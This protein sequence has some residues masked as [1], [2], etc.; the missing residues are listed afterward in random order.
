MS[1]DSMAQD[2]PFADLFPR[3]DEAQWQALVARVLKGKPFDRLVGRTADGLAIQPLYARLLEERPRAL[4]ETPGAWRIAARIDQPDPEEARA[5]IADDLAN[6]A[7][8]LHLVFGG[9]VGAC[10]FGLAHDPASLAT[11]LANVDLDAGLAIELD[12]GDTSHAA[13]DAFADLI[14]SRHVDPLRN[15]LAFGLDPFGPMLISGSSVTSMAQRLDSMAARCKMFAAR[16]FA[17]RF[18]MADGRPV[19]AAGGSEA[20]E[21]AFVLAAGIA[22][23]RALETAGIDLD[24]ARH[25]VSFRLVA[26]ADLF[27]TVAKLRALRALWSGVEAACGLTPQPLHLHVE[28]AWRMMSRRD[29]WVNL[30]R[31]TVACLGA[32]V[33][34]AD[35]VSVQPFTQALG[36]PDAFAR[37]LARNTQSILIA[38]AGIG[39]VADPVAGA[40]GFEALTQDMGIQAWALFQDIER[41]GGLRAQLENGRF[42]TQVGEAATQRAAR[43]ARRELPLTGTSEYP[44][45]AEDA[46]H[47]VQ[48]LGATPGL[49]SPHD[50]IRC[51]P[52][53]PR[54]DAAPYEALRDA[55][56]RQL[57]TTGQRPRVFLAN[58]GTASD[59]TPRTLF[60]RSL[61]E[62]GGIEAVGHDGYMNDGELVQAFHASG[63]SIACLCS[64]DDVY[65]ERAIAAAMALRDAGARR[66]WLAGR[67]GTL[68]AEWN[69]A[70][71][72]DFIFAGC[73][74]IAV[75]T[76]A[77]S[78]ASA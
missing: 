64:S 14:E 37:R 57:A 50:A 74:A 29:P 63:A 69:A 73:D 35:V 62:A 66:L 13:A 28:T 22:A 3:A 56:D 42:Q 58:L 31:A 25:M 9:S 32:G 40:G 7:D 59:F 77:Q 47:V 41:G 52:L 21:L 20:Q 75:L 4:R 67:P 38:E 72:K 16:G 43:I 1:E 70:G 24:A 30:L 23:L 61:F 48:P 46:V 5:Q 11:I 12:I 51:A 2:M 71:L 78:V 27:A 34:G 8:A 18:M 45:L 39:Q 65:A 15:R 33:A 10:G 60:A 17:G 36:L 76:L 54:R 53:S 49:P 68:Q 19:H 26:D 6:G 55:S 44:F